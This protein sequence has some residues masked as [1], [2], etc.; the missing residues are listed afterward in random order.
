MSKKF[1]NVSGRE[2]SVEADGVW[3]DVKPDEVLTL[4]DQFVA[5]HY[6]QTGD[7]G[8]DALWEPVAAAL[9]KPAGSGTTRDVPAPE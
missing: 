7:T 5:D 8:E 1:R 2:L 4:S 9:K 3:Q 6:I